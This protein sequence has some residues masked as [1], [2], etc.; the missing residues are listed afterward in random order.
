MEKIPGTKNQ[1]HQKI[2]NAGHFL[3]EDHTYDNFRQELWQPT[4]LSRQSYDD[5]KLGGST[6]MA[7]RVQGKT[8]DL[9]ESHEV[10]P[11]PNN[12]VSA[13]HQLK[14]AGEAELAQLANQ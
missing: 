9:T 11:L 13:L 3:Q 7:Q 10:A 6:S 4:L 2:V 1:P 12:I 8:I 5:W 14:Q